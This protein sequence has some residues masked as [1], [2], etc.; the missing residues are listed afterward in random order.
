MRLER[1][2]DSK[3]AFGTE[4]GLFNALGIPT[5]VCGPGS[6]VEAHKPDEFV[7][8]EQ[9]TLC[10]AFLARLT[11]VASHGIYSAIEGQI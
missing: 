10:E 6:I 5:V 2:D 9:M 8:I 3:V 11:A 7:S 1:R 4:G